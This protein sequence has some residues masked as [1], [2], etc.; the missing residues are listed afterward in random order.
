MLNIEYRIKKVFFFL[1]FLHSTFYILHSTA[2]WATELSGGTFREKRGY[3]SSHG[4]TRPV[5]TNFRTTGFN[6]Y[7]SNFAQSS[8]KF[9]HQS[10]FIP[11]YQYPGRVANLAASTGE[12]PGEIDLQFTAPGGSGDEVAAA[13]YEAHVSSEMPVNNETAW[14]QTARYVN[15]WS[16][17]APSNAENR[18]LS[19]P[20][21]ATTF[22]VAVRAFDQNHNQGDVSNSPSGFSQGAF[23]EISISGASYDFGTFTEVGSSVSASAPV[24]WNDGNTILKYSLKAAT[25]TAGTPWTLGAAQGIDTAVIQGAF[26]PARP[27]P[28]NFGAEDAVLGFEQFSQTPAQGGRYTID[29]SQLGVEVGTGTVRNLWLRFL[30]PLSTSTTDQQDIT[31]TVTAE[32][33]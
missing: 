31:M 23:V 22:Y 32:R 30:T 21:E 14:G 16:P 20:L 12:F 24:I 19:A 6:S 26:H 15:D 29:G 2:L 28:E 11:S 4:S 17:S 3:Y 33:Q 18:V 7:S 9:N 27:A 10:G 13:G 5:S 1:I 8:A 25:S